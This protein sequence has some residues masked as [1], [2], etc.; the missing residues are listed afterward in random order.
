MLVL[1]MML[2]MLVI[3]MVITVVLT[4]VRQELK[5]GAPHVMILVLVGRIY[6]NLVIL[7]FSGAYGVILQGCAF[8]IRRTG[9]FI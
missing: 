2:V 5:G 9:S 8:P 6:S 3:L 4:I 7:G 1:V